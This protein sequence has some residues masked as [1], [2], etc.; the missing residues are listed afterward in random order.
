MPWSESR[1][2]PDV[3][4]LVLVD[5]AFESTNQVPTVYSIEVSILVLVDLAFESAVQE[6]EPSIKDVFQ[7]LF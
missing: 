2:S 6:V 1:G 7:S 3:S 4:I 5:L